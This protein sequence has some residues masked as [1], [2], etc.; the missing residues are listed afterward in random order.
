MCSSGFFFEAVSMK[1]EDESFGV[2]GISERKGGPKK[3]L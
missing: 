3:K 1:N 2:L